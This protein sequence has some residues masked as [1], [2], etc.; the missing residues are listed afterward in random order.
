MRAG[1]S[2]GGAATVRG[3]GKVFALVSALST[4]KVSD[5]TA[6]APIRRLPT[7]MEVRK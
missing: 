6:A 3:L 7:R 1:G 4:R 5:P 2:F